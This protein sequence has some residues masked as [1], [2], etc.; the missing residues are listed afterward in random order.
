MRGGHIGRSAV[1][2]GEVRVTKSFRDPA[3]LEPRGGASA[4]FDWA[5][6]Q[7]RISPYSPLK[8]MLLAACATPAGG[9]R[10]LSHW[11]CRRAKPQPRSGDTFVHVVQPVQD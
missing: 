4:E 6:T 3:R 2:I 1:A 7:R 9:N 8:M 11:A 10:G 5:G